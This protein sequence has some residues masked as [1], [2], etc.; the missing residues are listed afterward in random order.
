MK[1]KHTIVAMDSHGNGYSTMEQIYGFRT[2]E[3]YTYL[4]C[5]NGECIVQFDEY[6][7]NCWKESVDFAMPN[8]LAPISDFIEALRKQGVLSRD[9]M[10]T[11]IYTEE[12]IHA[13]LNIFENLHL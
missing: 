7:T 9:E 5:G 6:I 1:I 4:I 2:S 3:N 13:E 11:D 12:Q 8:F 10:V